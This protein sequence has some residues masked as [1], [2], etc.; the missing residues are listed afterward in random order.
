M[1]SAIAAGIRRCQVRWTTFAAGSLPTSSSSTLFLSR[2]RITGPPVASPQASTSASRRSQHEQHV[3][4]TEGPAESL[5]LIGV[6]PRPGRDGRALSDGR[7]ARTARFGLRLVP[8][9]RSVTASPLRPVHDAAQ[10]PL[11]LPL[12]GDVVPADRLLETDHGRR[13]GAP[14]HLAPLL[15]FAA[16]LHECARLWAASGSAH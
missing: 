15:R 1:K 3:L 5:Q 9:R 11:H 8:S 10:R 12:R 7:R 4:D 14:R 16:D 13:A 2:S 6:Q